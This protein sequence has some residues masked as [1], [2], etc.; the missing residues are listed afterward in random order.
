[1]GAIYLKLDSSNGTLDYSLN[2][3]EIITQAF[4][5]AD[6]NDQKAGDIG[7][8]HTDEFIEAIATFYEDKA[9]WARLSLKLK[10]HQAL[11]EVR[12]RVIFF[13]KRQNKIK[14]VNT[15]NI[16]NTT[17]AFRGNDSAQSQHKPNIKS[18]IK[19]GCFITT[20][21]ETGSDSL[22]IESE[23]ALV[24]AEALDGYLSYSPSKQTWF[25]FSGYHWQS[26]DIRDLSSKVIQELLYVATDGLGFKPAYL[27][28]IKVLIEIGDMLPLP[29]TNH[30]KLPFQNGLL[31]LES[32]KLET[33]TS[34]NAATWVLPYAF[35]EKATCITLKAW[36][37]TAVDNDDETV[38]YLRAWLAAILHGM[39]E[40][41]KFLHLT[42]D[43]G[44]GKGVFLRLLKVLM[45][46]KNTVDTNLE[47]LEGNRFESAQLFNKRLCII[48]DS[49]KY[50]GSVNNLKAI[51]GQDYIRLER[52]HQQQADGF[53]YP[54]LLVMASNEYLQTT[55]HTSALDRRR[56]TVIFNR[57]ATDEEKAH[58]ESL[59]GEETVL[60]KEIPGLVNW[61]L[62][63]PKDEIRRIIRNPPK[64]VAN[65]NLAAMT[66]SNPIAEW[67]I[68]E[69]FPDVNAWTQ[70]GNKQ[71][72]R[73]H[74]QDTTILGSLDANDR[75]ERKSNYQ[76][77][78]FKNAD[79]W[80]YA[81][82]LQWC[83]R[84]HKSALSLTRFKGLVIQTCTTLKVHVS[85]CRKAEGAG[86]TGLRLKK[87]GEEW[88]F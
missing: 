13:F 32:K 48:S 34:R 86:L 66:T 2:P 61:L 72:V 87:A 65:A 67:L 1:M 69:C 43:A 36:L 18:K 11:T 15:L 42:G 50:G 10:K 23:A 56:A 62:E 7:A 3:K 20:N 57:R 71:E 28:N 35:D 41:Q 60:H 39:N 83:N 53:I 55:D 30:K 85:A 26:L 33:I 79:S 6:G 37:K 31:C 47:Q 21:D 59:G 68:E 49:D 24:I 29:E 51:T 84:T 77:I 75:L 14:K 16:V 22:I 74:H 25:E 46:V 38:Q 70:I 17:V 82:F 64:R 4:A 80:L 81:N 12:K 54:G 27:S 44:T 58:W 78:T 76:E 88:P 8:L 5:L 73:C 45:G 40:L 52:K 63:L 19:N 9:E